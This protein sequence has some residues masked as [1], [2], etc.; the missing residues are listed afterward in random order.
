MGE[1]Y[2]FLWFSSGDRWLLRFYTTGT[3]WPARLLENCWHLRWEL[4]QFGYWWPSPTLRWPTAGAGYPWRVSTPLSLFRNPPLV[5][6]AGDYNKPW[7]KDPYKPISKNW[8]VIRVLIDAHLLG[9]HGW[10]SLLKTT[11]SK[12][13]L[14]SFQ[15]IGWQGVFIFGW[16]G[17]WKYLQIW[18]GRYRWLCSGDPGDK[19]LVSWVSWCKY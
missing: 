4:W 14:K 16:F 19:T 5:G 10:I 17:A 6:D 12:V 13:F 18:E 3:T 15:H 8:N 11:R 2:G 9:I 7:C 1:T